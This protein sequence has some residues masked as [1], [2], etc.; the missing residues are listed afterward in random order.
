MTPIEMF[1]GIGLGLSLLLICLYLISR[2]IGNETL[3]RWQGED[4]ALRAKKRY[5][6]NAAYWEG[7]NQEMY[8]NPEGPTI[9][10]N[11]GG[12]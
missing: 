2:L 11:G 1:A 3:A 5:R 9:R 10:L 6:R 12:R 7:Y 4:D 8:G